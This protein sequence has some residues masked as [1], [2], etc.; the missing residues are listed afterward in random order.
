MEDITLQSVSNA[1]DENALQATAVFTRVHGFVRPFRRGFLRIVGSVE[2]ISCRRYG[3]PRTRCVEDSDPMLC[4]CP[5]TVPPDLVLR[6]LISGHSNVVVVKWSG[7]Q[8]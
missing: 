2:K 7:L 8:R 6:V 1:G 5:P 3:L 4:F